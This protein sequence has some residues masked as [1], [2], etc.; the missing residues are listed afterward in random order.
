MGKE[1]LCVE[2]DHLIRGQP[3]SDTR[4]NGFHLHYQPAFCGLQSDFRSIRILSCFPFAPFRH[5]PARKGFHNRFCFI[6][7]AD[8]LLLLLNKI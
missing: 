5:F 3:C 6:G 8:F 1:T 4:L 2:P 7:P